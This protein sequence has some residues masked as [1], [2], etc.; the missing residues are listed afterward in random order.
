[1][2][3]P[4]PGPSRPIPRWT[5]APG[6]PE[7]RHPPARG[8]GLLGKSEIRFIKALRRRR[9]GVQLAELH[10][11]LPSQARDEAVG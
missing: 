11:Q 4:L 7:V 5:S 3:V 10:R 8:P 2:E 9:S 1:V 6:D